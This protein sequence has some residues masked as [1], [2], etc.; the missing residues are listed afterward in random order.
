MGRIFTFPSCWAH[1]RQLHEESSCLNWD[2]ERLI[3]EGA[4]YIS[5]HDS[6]IFLMGSDCCSLGKSEFAFPSSKETGSPRNSGRVPH[7]DPR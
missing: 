4:A 2:V 7:L 6:L 1:L 3:E 5:N